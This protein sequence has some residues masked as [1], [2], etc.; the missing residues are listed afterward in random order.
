MASPFMHRQMQYKNVANLPNAI[1]L[2]RVP[3]T[4]SSL[5]IKEAQFLNPEIKFYGQNWPD[6]EIIG[7]LIERSQNL[8][9]VDVP[10]KVFSQRFNNPEN[11]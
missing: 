9:E 5:I 4:L 8:R 2:L 11:I 7:T 10:L 6:T 3:V 1:H